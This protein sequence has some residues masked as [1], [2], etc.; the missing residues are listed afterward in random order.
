MSQLGAWRF[1]K[2]HRAPGHAC[3]RVFQVRGNTQKPRVHFRAC[4]PNLP[5]GDKTG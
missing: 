2:L 4:T 5:E 1:G 3:E